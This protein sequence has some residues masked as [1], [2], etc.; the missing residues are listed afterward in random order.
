[1][2]SVRINGSV[3]LSWQPPEQNVDGTPLTDLAGYR[4]H[5][6]Q[7]SR[8]YTES[9]PINGTA[10]SDYSLTLSSGDYY[11]AM[12]AI[13]ADGNESGYSNEVLKTVL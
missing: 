7:Q 4:I 6:G 1:M 10:R 3:T 8:N 5:Y 11:F 9:I 13:D 2:I 12:T